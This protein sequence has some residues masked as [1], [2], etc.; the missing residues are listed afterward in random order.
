M[1]PRSIQLLEELALNNI[2][3]TKPGGG[4]P[5]KWRCGQCS[6]LLGAHFG[7]PAPLKYRNYDWRDR[8]IV[9]GKITQLIPHKDGCKVVEALRLVDASRR[10]HAEGV[11]VRSSGL[12]VHPNDNR[13]MAAVDLPHPKEEKGE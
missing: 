9:W 1:I 11:L 3:H 6:A 13:P 12:S 7:S 8:Y 2:D 5:E 10:L 4:G